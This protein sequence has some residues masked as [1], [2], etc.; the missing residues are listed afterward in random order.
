MKGR[1]SA[2]RVIPREAEHGASLQTKILQNLDIA[3]NG[4]GRLHLHRAAAL[5]AHAKDSIRKSRPEL[6]RVTIA[7]EFRRGC[8]LVGMSRAL[9][10]PDRVRHSGP[11]HAERLGGAG[12]RV[13]CGLMGFPMLLC[14]RLHGETAHIVRELRMV[15]DPEILETALARSLGH[16][17]KGLGPVGGIRV[18]VKDPA[19]VFVGDQLLRQHPVQGTLDFAAPLPELRFDEGR[20]RAR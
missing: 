6:K 16:G 9:G 8:E 15:G 13:A 10:H 11:A 20:P 7:G 2:P 5:L 18:V 17:L 12:R 14:N 3:K 4:E 19:Q 1:P